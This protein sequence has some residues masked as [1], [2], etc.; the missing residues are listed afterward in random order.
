VWQW[1][2]IALAVVFFGT[3]SYPTIPF[4]GDGRLGHR[5]FARR[6]GKLILW[7][8]GVRLTA[9]GADSLDAASPAVIVANHSSHYAFYALAAMLPVQWRAVI[10]R[11]MRRIPI[12]GHLGEKAGHV[13]IRLGDTSL[14][15][16]DLQPGMERL[17][18]GYWLLVFPEGRPSPAGGIGRFKKGAFRL[19]IE[20]GVP[21]LPIS[22]EEI[23]AESQGRNWDS[24]PSRIVLRV[25]PPIETTNLTI[26]DTGALAM[27]AQETILRGLSSLDREGDPHFCTS[28]STP[29]P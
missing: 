15:I 7:W 29:A 26:N 21:V 12:F 27:R 1:L 22:I 23:Y 5:L 10:R 9:R 16:R 8:C 11:E 20:A 14:A 25:L 2:G 13:F 4:S 19:A 6:W 28:R 24:A 18:A 17:Q 3:I